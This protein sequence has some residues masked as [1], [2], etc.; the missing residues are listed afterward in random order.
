MRELTNDEAR[1]ID[2]TADGRVRAR[3]EQQADIHPAVLKVLRSQDLET[4]HLLVAFGKALKN[5]A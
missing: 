5:I 4:G 1:V 3:L 2:G